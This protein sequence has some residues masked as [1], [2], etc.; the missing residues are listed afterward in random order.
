MRVCLGD[1]GR[2]YPADI[3]HVR[4]LWRL[5]QRACG[6]DVTVGLVRLPDTLQVRRTSK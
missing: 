2:V 5:V 6:R 3:R 4:S 1:I